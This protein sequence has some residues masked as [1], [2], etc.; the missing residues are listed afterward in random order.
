MKGDFP[1]MMDKVLHIA[2]RLSSLRMTKKRRE[3][4]IFKKNNPMGDDRMWVDRWIG[5]AMEL[6]K[7]DDLEDLKVKFYLLFV[8]ASISTYFPGCCLTDCKQA[9]S[10]F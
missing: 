6:L 8:S 10:Q 7:E 3:V 4:D 1:N 9:Q 5:L 2:T